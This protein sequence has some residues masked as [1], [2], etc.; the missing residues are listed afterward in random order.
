[1]IEKKLMSAVIGVAALVQTACA[2]DYLVI[3]PHD[4]VSAWETYIAARSNSVAGAGL[5]FAVK[6]AAAIYAGYAFDSANTNGSPRNPAESIHKFLRDYKA[7]NT[8]LKY[9]VLGGAWIDA[10]NLPTDLYFEGTDIPVSTNNA[11]PGVYVYSNYKSSGGAYGPYPSDMF[12]ACLDIPASG[13]PWDVDGDGQYLDDDENLLTADDGGYQ[14]DYIPD[15]VVSRIPLKTANGYSSN[16]SFKDGSGNVLSLEDLLS[17]YTAKLA[18]GEGESFSGAGSFAMIAGAAGGE[19]REEWKTAEYNFYDGLPNCQDSDYASGSY[20][21]A[22]LA[23]RRRLRDQFAANRP[24]KKADILTANWNF[25]RDYSSWNNAWNGYLANDHEFE[26]II[27][28]GGNN[29]ALV[30]STWTFG[31]DT[32]GSMTGL[33]LF[34]DFGGPCDTGCPDIQSTVDGVNYRSPSYADAAVLNPNGGCLATINNARAGV[35]DNSWSLSLDGD[36]LSSRHAN[37]IAEAFVVEGKNAGEAWLYM[38]RSKGRETFANANNISVLVQEMFYGDPLVKAPTV[39]EPLVAAD[40]TKVYSRVTD[41]NIENLASETGAVKVLG[42]L[43]TSS[44]TLSCAFSGGIGGAGV[45]F[46][47]EKGKLTVSNDYGFYLAG[48]TN[49]ALVASGHNMTVDLDGCDFSSADD[50]SIVAT[51]TNLTLRSRVAGAITTKLGGNLYLRSGAQV[52]LDTVDA[53]GSTIGTITM[54]NGS[55]IR[56]VN[57]AEPLNANITLISGAATIVVAKGVDFTAA[58]SVPDGVTIVYEDPDA[59]NN[60][61]FSNTGV[62][63]S[64]MDGA[65]DVG[66]LN[67]VIPAT[68]DAPSGTTIY[69]K[70]I[71]FSYRDSSYPQYL[72]LSESANADMAS[73]NTVAASATSSDFGGGKPVTYYFRNLPLVVGTTYRCYGRDTADSNVTTNQ[74]NLN[75]MPKNSDYTV[76]MPN[77][78]SNYSML[79]E[80]RCVL[81]ASAALLYSWEF[82]GAAPTTQTVDS[83]EGTSTLKADTSALAYFDETSLALSCTPYSSTALTAPVTMVVP[84]ILPTTTSAVYFSLGQCRDAYALATG[85]TTGTIRLVKQTGSSQYTATSVTTLVDDVAV[86]DSEKEHLYALEVAGAVISAYLDGEKFFAYTNDSAIALSAGFQLGGV[87]YGTG[88]TYGLNKATD[89]SVDALRIYDGILTTE[90]WTSLVNEFVPDTTVYVAE[91]NGAKYATLKK[92]I[93]ASNSSYDITMLA[94]TDETVSFDALPDAKAQAALKNSHF[95]G[96]A[97]F[98]AFTL[99]KGTDLS[100]YANANSTVRLG[101]VENYFAQAMNF[102]GTVELT[103]DISFTDGYGDSTVMIAKLAGSGSWTIGSGYSDNLTSSKLGYSIG[104]ITDYSGTIKIAS[105]RINLEIGSDSADSIASGL[106]GYVVVS[107]NGVYSISDA[108]TITNEDGS[109]ATIAV[110]ASFFEKYYSSLTGSGQGSSRAAKLAETAANGANKVW[111]CYALGLDPT[112]KSAA[113]TVTISFGENGEV[114][115]D[116][117]PSGTVPAGEIVIQGASSLGGEWHDKKDGDRFFKA[118]LEMSH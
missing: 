41:A 74:Y 84:G 24:V 7:A 25:S 116:S 118:V 61:V 53:F 12:Y 14:I 72:V 105:V 42:G 23:I 93:D 112:S 6:D 73:T 76:L 36:G 34:S 91:V 19:Y 92:A 1:M 16:C 90:Q 4:L 98:T 114:K 110:P 50:L 107:S 86:K 46:T 111:E 87:L 15:I 83:A 103:K 32:M 66:Y 13:Y 5:K 71:A 39:A 79:Y 3:A 47:G 2:A 48:V 11:V 33:N 89:G 52:N 10:Q 97:D 38:A 57:S 68:E 69:L 81:D 80:V 20:P 56:I 26:Y 8:N 60:L 96:T 99:A 28:H 77:N 88:K 106:D 101:S 102:P 51:V 31:A 22:E 45:V 100:P 67:L 108:V 109:T 35:Y 58:G 63:Y 59:A 85:E 40:E 44:T 49:G 70:S 37:R 17:A 117:S 115:I 95:K 9:V 43:E 29:W 30:T 104:D 54:L 21:G 94:D 62:S 75:L 78:Y 18:R 113:F 82:N 65:T 64:K 27:S 55:S